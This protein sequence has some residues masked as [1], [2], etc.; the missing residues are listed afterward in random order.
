MRK[1]ASNVLLCLMPLLG[2]TLFFAGCKKEQPQ[3]QPPAPQSKPAVK[4]S[5]PIQKQATSAKAAGIAAQSLDFSKKKDPFKPFI[6][7]ET[8][9]Q[10]KAKPAIVSRPG[11]LLPI[12]NYDVNKFRVSGII[13]G[14]RENSA[15]IIDPTGRGYVVKVGMLIGNNNGRISRIRPSSL[16]VV[17]QYRDDK[18][19]TKKNTIVLPLSKKK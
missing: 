11:D 2:A 18:G 1:K 14:L 7:V 15:L 12:Q 3:T 17:E 9:P 10:Q 8:A 13:V 4:P 5:L 6:V 19:R 16:E